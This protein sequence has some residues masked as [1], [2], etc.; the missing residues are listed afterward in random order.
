MNVTLGPLLTESALRPPGGPLITFHAYAVE[1]AANRAGQS[2]GTFGSLRTVE[3]AIAC[4]APPVVD[5]L[6]SARAI[7]SAPQRDVESVAKAGAEVLPSA[8]VATTETW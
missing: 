2:A 7:G 6:L 8:S 1:V 5:G 4:P 3:S